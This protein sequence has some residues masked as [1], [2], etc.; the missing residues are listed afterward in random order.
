[1]SKPVHIY[2]TEVG[3]LYYLR[4][5]GSPDAFAPIKKIIFPT[6]DP[7]KHRTAP[8]GHVPVLSYGQIVMIA[9]KWGTA[10]QVVVGEDV[11]WI[12]NHP[13][14]GC[15]EIASSTEV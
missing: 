6:P 3:K 15:E 5:I 4:F 14:I 2:H 11:V 7:E 9:Q 1:M 8:E 13:W 12:K 10:I